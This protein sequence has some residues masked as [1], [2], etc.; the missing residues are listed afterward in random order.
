MTTTVLIV[1]CIAALLALFTWRIKVGDRKRHAITDPI[2]TIVDEATMEEAFSR[3]GMHEYWPKA[4]ALVRGQAVLHTTPAPMEVLSIG[5]SRIGGVPDLPPDRMWPRDAQGNDLGFLA[6]IDLRE[7]GRYDPEGL[8]PRTG[9]LSFFFGSAG[10]NY[11]PETCAVLYV[12]G[13]TAQLDRKTVPDSVPDELRFRS[14]SVRFERRVSL[15]LEF[16]RTDDL[17]LPLEAGD[18]LMDPLK[19]DTAG[20]KLLGWPDSIQG[21]PEDDAL[22]SINDLRAPS[23]HLDREDIRLLFQVDSEEEKTGMTWGDAGMVYFLIA[24]SDLQSRRFDRCVAIL[25]CH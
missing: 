3:L 5:A 10:D 8:L 2:R 18:L 15:P 16:E 22:A 12:D 7:A 19:R 11:D 17:D 13:D 6:Q 25:Q 21:P 20:N 14:C 9:Q 1:L 23:Q 24:G 4:K